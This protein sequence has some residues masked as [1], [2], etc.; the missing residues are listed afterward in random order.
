[1]WVSTGFSVPPLFMA[2]QKELSL[3]RISVA[4]ESAENECGIKKIQVVTPCACF[5][6][7]FS[8]YFTVNAETFQNLELNSGC[9]TC[10]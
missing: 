8:R 5:P 7:S 10:A 2:V 1:M 4:L 9:E 3:L 6:T